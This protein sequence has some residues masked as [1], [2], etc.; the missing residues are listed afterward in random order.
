MR[1]F[2]AIFALNQK[3]LFV[4]EEGGQIPHH[5]LA[6]AGFGAREFGVVGA[7]AEADSEADRHIV[8]EQCAVGR[9]GG[10]FHAS[11]ETGLGKNVADLAVRARLLDA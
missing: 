10:D 4:A 11:P 3:H 9:G 6:F 5:Q 8:E 2:I 7:R 1:Q